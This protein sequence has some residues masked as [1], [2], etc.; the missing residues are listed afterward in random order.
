MGRGLLKGGSRAFSWPSSHRTRVAEGWQG[1]TLS[2]MHRAR[3]HLGATLCA[4]WTSPQAT[5]SC[6][7]GRKAA[8]LLRS[9]G[10]PRPLP[11]HRLPRSKAALQTRASHTLPRFCSFSCPPALSCSRAGWVGRQG[12]APLLPSPPALCCPPP[13]SACPLL[14]LSS[15]PLLCHSCP[16][17][18]LRP[19]LEF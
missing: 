10:F 16:L 18:E 9:Q 12:T 8:T 13:A 6:H 4:G 1:G 14:C 3:R 17:G 11:T 7:A 15:L 2:K 5:A 19:R